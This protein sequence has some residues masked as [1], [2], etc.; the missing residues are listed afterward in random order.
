MNRK[1]LNVIFKNL[2]DLKRIN[3]SKKQLIGIDSECF[4]ELVNLEE[5]DLSNNQLEKIFKETFESL[6][7]LKWISLSNNLIRSIET[8]YFRNLKN[9]LEIDLSYNKIKSI[10]SDS[11]VELVML[12]VL[13]LS[14][15]QLQT[16]NQNTFKGLV[17]LKN[18]SLRKNNIE[19]VDNA[20][21]SLVSLQKIDLSGNHLVDIEKNTFKGLTFLESIDL[22]ENKFTF[23]EKIKLNLEKSVQ[24]VS[25]FWGYN[26]IDLILKNVI[27]NSLL[28]IYIFIFLLNV[29][30]SVQLTNDEEHELENKT[31]HLQDQIDS[32]LVIFK[33]KDQDQ[34]FKI[35]SDLKESTMEHDK[36]MPIDENNN[37]N[38][39]ESFD[40]YKNRQERNLPEY[41]I[42]DVNNDIDNVVDFGEE[43]L[44]SK[45]ENTLLVFIEENNK[46]LN[47]E[48]LTN[49]VNEHD[50][51]EESEKEVISV[52][53]DL[54]INKYK[55]EQNQSQT[56]SNSIVVEE[57][58]QHSI[59]KENI[60]DSEITSNINSCSKKTE[61]YNHVDE[62]FKTSKDSDSSKDKISLNHALANL[63]LKNI[64]SINDEK[65]DQFAIRKYEKTLVSKFQKEFPYS[66]SSS[67][68]RYKNVNFLTVDKI[69]SKTSKTLRLIS[70]GSIYFKL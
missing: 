41:N 50:G 30:I 48:N 35:E 7:N 47:D 22:Y 10:E 27:I 2:D 54:S 29:F 40:E 39:F 57:N 45:I 63:S 15:N 62:K 18:I 5:I 44:I 17:N 37:Q 28:V 19:R 14:F 51:L 53:V 43:N 21:G 56:I 24:F 64:Q 4:L 46:D 70:P 11:F 59:L 6:I 65:D 42:N 1:W 66:A 23:C 55:S 49:T 9:L 26:G 33:E 67:I 34:E 69:R 16:A 8:D 38:I 52:A 36:I 61:I 32:D 58:K 60:E 3:L 68:E 12:Q 13:D 25:L 20:F 31:Q